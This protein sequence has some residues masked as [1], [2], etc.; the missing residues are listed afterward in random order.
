MF[1]I[2]EDRITAEIF[3][4]GVI[5]D[6]GLRTGEF[7][8]ML[9]DAEA[10]GAKQFICRINSPG[11]EVFEAI[12]IFNAL[13]ERDVTISIEG[14][15]A[16]SASFIAMAGKR[17]QMFDNAVMMIHNP[18][19]FAAG[20]ANYFEK[21]Q[22]NLA[23]IK[24]IILKAYS[25]TGL[26][27]NKLTKMMDEETWLSAQESADHKFVDE[28]ITTNQTPQN[29][30]KIKTQYWNMIL[31]E[32]IFTRKVNQMVQIQNA[33]NMPGA[34]EKQLAQGILALQKVKNELGEES[35]TLK[36]ELEKKQ[37][38]IAD[39]EKEL[40]DI[41]A[42]LEAL[43]KE[44]A[45]AETAQ[46]EQKAEEILV[47]AVAEGKIYPAEIDQTS[48]KGK[49]NRKAYLDRIKMNAEVFDAMPVINKLGAKPAVVPQGQSKVDVVQEAQILVADMAKSGVKMSYSE[50][51]DKVMRKHNLK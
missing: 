7:T 49:K 47:K 45:T 51:V 2:L 13:A 50:A 41:K 44:K 36:T 22:E 32:S 16:S 24:D 10:A 39:K 12:G 28:V 11:G 23:M 27:E 25:R 37:A 15:A 43:E 8:Q 19:T 34:D 40:N 46:A 17:V 9:H 20:D 6:E 4:M 33:L 30:S 5:G 48:E 31:D 18:W 14:L 1:R 38:E 35:K 42:K 29:K 21:V 26:P 3:I